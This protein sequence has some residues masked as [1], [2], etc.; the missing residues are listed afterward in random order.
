MDSREVKAERVRLGKS[1]QDVADI[2]QISIRSY[3]NKENSIRPFSDGEKSRLT[4]LFGWSYEQMNQILYDNQL[5]F[6]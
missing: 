5:P 3:R 6:F 1:Q 4:T 2:L